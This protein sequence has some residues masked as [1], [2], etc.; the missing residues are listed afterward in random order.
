MEKTIRVGDL[1]IQ[2]GRY[3]WRIYFRDHC[4][5]N[6]RPSDV[7]L[8]KEYVDSGKPESGIPTDINRSRL[9]VVESVKLYKFALE[10]GMNE[11]ENVTY[12]LRDYVVDKIRE[13][14][15]IP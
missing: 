1:V 7:K 14:Q 11:H 15:A 3:Y 13:A 9:S 8:T 5:F 4:V 12:W 10:Q 6:M 2:E